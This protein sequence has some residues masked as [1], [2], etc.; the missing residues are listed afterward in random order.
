MKMALSR[1][2]VL[3]ATIM[4]QE[5]WINEKS[6]VITG[7]ANPC[8][9]ANTWKEEVSIIGY[10]K[11]QNGDVWIVRPGRGSTGGE[12]GYFYFEMNENPL[13]LESKLVT[14]IAPKY[15]EEEDG[16]VTR[17]V[18]NRN[19]DKGLLEDTSSMCPN[20]DDYFYME[21]DNIICTKSCP[22]WAPYMEAG[23]LC[24]KHCMSGIYQAGNFC[25][26]QCDSKSY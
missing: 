6:S 13:C 16:L 12:S 2:F 23:R 14:F 5:T 10:G 8:N 1:G 7:I 19:S 4:A 3:T 15:Y 17:G 24:T 21:G 26:D 11:K 20:D 25:L 18:T 9:D 22:E